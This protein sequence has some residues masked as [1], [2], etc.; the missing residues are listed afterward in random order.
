MQY[1]QSIFQVS[2]ELPFLRDVLAEQLAQIGYDSFVEDDGDI[3]NAYIQTALYD[4]QQLQ[5]V[6]REFP[7]EGVTYIKT[8]LCEDKDWNEEW[9]KNYL[10]PII[11][12]DR[13]I[14]HTSFQQPNKDYPY[15]II[16]N[17]K[18]AFGTGHHQTTSLILQYLL[19]ADL[20]GKSMLDMG[21]GTGVLAIL[22]RKRGANPV[23]AIDI[24]NWCTDNTRENCDI[25]NID[26]IEILTGD[27]ALTEGRHFDMIV[28]NINRNILLMDMPRYAA[29]L[30]SN[31]TL[32]ISGFYTE[33]V[34]ILEEKACQMG[35]RLNLVRENQNWA[36]MC[37]SMTNR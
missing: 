12:N 24:D 26:D 37:L 1:S 7:F 31:G 32:I 6:L 33:D 35:L 8:E 18:M 34:T 14:I 20:E 3:L 2:S 29:S 17:P 5:H 21:C 25:N 9:E 22:A 13:C 30:N 19:E 10:Q 27:A 4:N 15:D 11:I 36:M 16:I 28:A 23:T